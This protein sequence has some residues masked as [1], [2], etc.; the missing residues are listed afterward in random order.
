MKKRILV[1]VAIEAAS[2][3]ITAR[4]NP[5]PT[6]IIRV[7]VIVAAILVTIYFL[8]DWLYQRTVERFARYV[9]RNYY[10][11]FNLEERQRLALG[12]YLSCYIEGIDYSTARGLTPTLELRI[13]LVN[14]SVFSV[15]NR[16]LLC[17]V[18]TKIA[19][20]T[21]PIPASIP[22]QTITPGGVTSYKLSFAITSDLVS[23]IQEYAKSSRVVPFSVSLDWIFHSERC[24][25]THLRTGLLQYQSIPPVQKGTKNNEL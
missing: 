24:G 1:E 18:E 8:W 3:A 22:S 13:Q 9:L 2:I 14:R 17:S 7:A 16:E 12:D 6:L 4:I 15:S 10:W 20:N 23:K 25:D 21:L 5:D 11:L 19:D